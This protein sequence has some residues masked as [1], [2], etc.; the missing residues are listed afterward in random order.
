MKLSV[1]ICTNVYD[2]RL[3]LTI[4]SCIEQRVDFDFEVVIVSNGCNRQQILEYLKRDFLH[5]NIILLS[6]NLDGLIPSLNHGLSVCSGEYV[7]RVDVGDICLPN[8]WSQ[9][10][11]KLDGNSSLAIIG[12]QIRVVP[13]DENFS[14]Y[15]LTTKQIFTTWKNPFAHPAVMFRKDIVLNK[16]GYKFPYAAEDYG[17]WLELMCIDGLTFENLPEEVILYERDSE[18]GH[19][20]IRSAY[21]GITLYIAYLF[22]RTPKKFLIKHFARNLIQSI[23][24]F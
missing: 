24:R 22:L 1:L 14:S 23:M 12:G 13:P 11:A 10:V 7:G 2:D 3:L 19:R 9:Q 18:N 16:G 17:L 8:R 21:Y 20:K 6:C 15:P 4:N 5:D